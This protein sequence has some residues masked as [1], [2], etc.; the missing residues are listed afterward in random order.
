[1]KFDRYEVMSRE[2]GS[3]HRMGQ[4]STSSTYKALDLDLH[5]PVVLKV[6]RPELLEDDTTRKRFLREARAAALI[7][8][9]NVA[10]IYR[11]AEEDG[12]CFYAREFIAGETLETKV[13]RDGP[14]EIAQALDITLQVA[15]ALI[16]FKKMNLVHRE[17]KPSNLM[18]T[19][20]STVKIIDFGLAKLA[21]IHTD[22]LGS[23][24]LAGFV[25][26]PDYSS[27]EQLNEQEL[28]STS[29]I[30]SLGVTLW[31]LLCGRP[32]FRGPMAQVMA[33]HL[34]EMP[35][36]EELSAFP[37]AVVSLLAHM[38]EKD[39]LKRPATPAHLAAEIERC[40][41]QLQSGKGGETSP[42]S[43]AVASFTPI[44]EL[45]KVSATRVPVTEPPRRQFAIE[46]LIGTMIAIVIYTILSQPV[47]APPPLQTLE[48]SSPSPTPEVKPTP[49][50]KPTA[51]AR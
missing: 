25:G 47:E 34:Q 17:I 33:R 21:G 4:G 36:F 44:P 3:I 40:M 42:A 10:T 24:T 14:F 31:F 6:I 48:M 51:V 27:P 39:P 49:E 9:P 12:S 29:D 35:P 20:D 43:A 41:T 11:L 13:Q 15:R 28:D 1:M 18:L 19:S 8:H 46:I 16:A 45:P 30:Y 23:I 32:P 38:L 22:G 26:S 7:R 50:A 37:P 5:V 2:D